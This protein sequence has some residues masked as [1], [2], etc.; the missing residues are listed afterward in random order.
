[1][2]DKICKHCNKKYNRVRESNW[3]NVDSSYY[4]ICTPC[5]KKFDKRIDCKTC[6]GDR[7]LG[8]KIIFGEESCVF[9]LEKM[10]P[11]EFIIPV[12]DWWLIPIGIFML[13]SMLEVFIGIGLYNFILN[14]PIGQ[15]FFVVALITMFVGT[16]IVTFKKIKNGTAD[17]ADYIGFIM[18]TIMFLQFL[19]LYLTDS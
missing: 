19:F 18:F 5:E 2:Q 1:M 11:F 6:D 4:N 9:C 15:I 10:K 8:R 14:N 7:P 17:T 3:G 13:A 12:K 16:Y